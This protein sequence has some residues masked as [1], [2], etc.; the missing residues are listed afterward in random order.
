MA[1]GIDGMSAPCALGMSRV[2]L[3]SEPVA[4]IEKSTEPAHRLSVV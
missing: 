1:D 3:C 2:C 4:Q